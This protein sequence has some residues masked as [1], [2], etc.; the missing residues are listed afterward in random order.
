MSGLGPK[1]GASQFLRKA[2]SKE[3]LNHI[4][5]SHENLQDAA[6]EHSNGPVNRLSPPDMHDITIRRGGESPQLPPNES[7]PFLGAR[8]ASH[9]TSVHILPYKMNDLSSFWW[10]LKSNYV[11]L[12]LIFA[13]LGILSGALNWGPGLT[14]SLNFLAIIPEAWLLGK[15]TEELACRTGQIVGGLLNATFG[16]AVEIIVSFAALLRGPKLVR[17]VQGSLLG[18]ILS[19]LLL[20]MGMS[21]LFGGIYFPRQTFNA[22]GAVTFS[23][24]LTLSSVG[25]ILPTAFSQTV[26]GQDEEKK[27]EGVSHFTALVL[28]LMY[29]LY[30]FF[31]LHTHSEMFEDEEEEEDEAILSL[32]FTIFLLAAVTALVAVNSE[33]LVGSIEAVQQNYGLSEMFIGIILLPIVGNAAEHVTAVTVAVKDKMDLSIGVAV[34]SS[35]QIAL[36]V[37]PLTVVMGWIIDVPMTLNFELFETT[38]MLVSVLIVTSTLNDGE[39]N[40][41]EGAMLVSVYSIIGV[42][43]WF[44]DGSGEGAPALLQAITK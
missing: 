14:F 23:S 37:V 24:L 10:I 2:L 33:Y 25:L 38:I 29:G 1:R 32:W 17:V 7:S 36:L 8:R 20:V 11:N 44:H 6:G 3:Y 5:Q 13:P 42:A 18:S 15:A 40:W 9:Y 26:A 31:Q 39:S 28:M 12:L 30:L 16:N 4:A 27:L 19:N 41:L 21:F 34:G 43:C 22:R 35:I